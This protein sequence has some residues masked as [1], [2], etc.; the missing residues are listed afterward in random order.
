MALL[1]RFCNCSTSLTTFLECVCLVSL[2][3]HLGVSDCYVYC[4][5]WY[6]LRV[7]VAQRAYTVC[8]RCAV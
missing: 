2:L 3:S 5:T 4:T 6:V 7:R 8:S 1:L